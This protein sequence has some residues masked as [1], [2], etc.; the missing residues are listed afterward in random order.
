VPIPESAYG[1]VDLPSAAKTVFA[2]EITCL[3]CSRTIGTAVDIRWPPISTVLVRFEGD[4]RFSDGYRFTNYAVRTVVGIRR[5]PRSRYANSAASAP[6]TGRTSNRTGV[7]CRS[8]W[9]HND[10][11]PA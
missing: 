9:W 4:G 3:M 6:S 8:G 11:P 10:K 2:A 7:G 1:S 5:P